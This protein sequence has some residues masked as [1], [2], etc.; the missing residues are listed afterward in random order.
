VSRRD[1]DVDGGPLWNASTAQEIV[2]VIAE[3][4]EAGL[5]TPAEAMELTDR[6][7]AR[8]VPATDVPIVSEQER[9]PTGLHH[10]AL[11]ASVNPRAGL[12]GGLV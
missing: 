4:L 8:V 12:R 5:L 3:D 1:D 6:V 2:T 10:R 9:G 7:G 11:T